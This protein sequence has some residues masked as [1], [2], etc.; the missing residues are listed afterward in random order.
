MLYD[1]IIVGA[2]PAG[3]TA[4]IYAVRMGLKT[5][6]L[7]K[8][9][10]G[11]LML[12]AKEIE[13]YPGFDGISGEELANRMKNQAKNLGVE[14]KNE[15]VIGMDLH[16]ETKTVTTRGG[17][18]AT[19]SIITATGS[20]YRKLEVEGENEFAGKGVSF[21]AICDAPFFAD[22]VVAVV[23]GGN[24][25][26]SDA[27]YLN[28]IAKKTYL[29]HRRDELRAEEMRQ[30]KLRESGVEIILNSVVEEILGDNFVKSIRIRDV[31]SD[32]TRELRVDGV[33]I[34]I[35]M[36]PTTV[37]VKGAGI[38]LDDKGFIEVNRNQETN[39][40]GVFA[41]GDCTGGL[42]QITTATG[43]GSTA[44]TSAYN[45]IKSPYWSE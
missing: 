17:R 36:V 14:I 9:M 15:E 1:V 32:K 38:K 22:R 24:S 12:L 18:Y 16:T 33:F 3:I 27:L 34:S 21:C 37:M 2:G 5:L 20:E 44:A 19:K 13:N 42:R 25:A 4:S 39:I 6:V 28:E 11:G 10:V 43:E 31:S 7:E 23:G 8:G 26:A 29:I 40:S 35:G 45:Y 30:E 41:A